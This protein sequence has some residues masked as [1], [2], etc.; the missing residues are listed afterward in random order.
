M[1]VTGDR[2]DLGACRWQGTPRRAWA[3]AG[4]GGAL[5]GLGQAPFDLWFLAIPALAIVLGLVA[6]APD[7]RQAA[8]LAWLGATG[9]FAVS[10]HWIVEPFFVDAARHGWMAPFA[11][12]LMAGGLALFWAVPGWVIGRVLPRGA[13]AA[14][15]VALA[16]LLSLAEVLRGVLFTGFPWAQPGHVLIDTPALA[17]S[18]LA[19]PLGLTALVLAFATLTGLAFFWR[20]IGVSAAIVAVGCLAIHLAPSPGAPEPD[21]NAPVIRLVQPNAPQHLKWQRDMIPVFFA[22]GLDLTAAPADP[23]LGPPDLVVWPETSLPELL[24]R[25]EAARTR[26]AQAAGAA[27]VVV[28][29]QRAAGR[30]PV[31]S[32]ALLSADG[33]IMQVYDK[34]HLVPFGEYLPFGDLLAQFGLRGL[35]EALP[36]GYVPGEGP[37]LLDLGA[38]LGRAFP[39]ICY[40]AIFPGYVRQVPARP[41][42]MLHITNDAWFGTFSGPYQHLALARLRAAEQGL[43]VLRAANT[44]ISAVIDARGQVVDVLPLGEAGYLDARLPAARAPTVFARVGDGPMLAIL[45]VMALGALAL[46]RRTAGHCA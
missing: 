43:P 28:G 18:A 32:L 40:E 23:D 29:A 26:I 25:S 6:A 35:A 39:M 1:S 17:L 14:R 21:A 38:D 10:L 45:I 22:R 41:D 11:L 16:A 31:N 30:R 37:A 46:G 20:G 5:A 2:E 34:H 15:M 3:L 27:Q 24:D 4:L 33:A 13:I 36:G 42:W 7:P 19:G 12:A 44:G 9:Y 8:R